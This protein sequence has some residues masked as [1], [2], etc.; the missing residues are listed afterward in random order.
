MKRATTAESTSTRAAASDSSAERL[1]SFA[2]LN[3]FCWLMPPNRVQLLP[4]KKLFVRTRSVA[5]VLVYRSMVWPQLY[6]CVAAAF[7]S[8]KK[9]H[10]AKRSPWAAN[11]WS[12][13]ARWMLRFFSSARPTHWSRV[14]ACWAVR[15]VPVISRARV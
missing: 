10:F 9:P 5:K 4:R 3:W 12:Y 1:S 14:Q 8:G 15:A 13:A 2:F 6:P 11:S 7:R